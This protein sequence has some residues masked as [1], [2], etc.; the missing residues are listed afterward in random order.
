MVDVTG[1][2]EVS[3]GEQD[4]SRRKRKRPSLILRGSI[5]KLRR[6]TKKKRRKNS[7]SVVS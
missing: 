6:S 3:R 5:N 4:T 2:N 7:E 1:T